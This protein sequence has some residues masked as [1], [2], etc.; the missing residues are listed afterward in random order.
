MHVAFI[1]DGNRRWAKK[2]NIN[3]RD[4]YKKGIELFS[5]VLQWS[6]ELGVNEVSIWAISYD[7]YFNRPKEEIDTLFSLFEEYYQT[8]KDK[9]EEIIKKYPEIENTR[10]YIGGYIE[11]LEE[12]YRKYAEEINNRIVKDEKYR[13]NFLVIYNGRIEIIKALEKMK[14][15]FSLEDS[16]MLNRYP[17]IIIRT[18]GRVR[19]SGFLPIQSEYSEWY[20]LEKLWP[21]FDKEDYIKILEDFQTRQRNFGK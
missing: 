1:P 11:V 4:A 7:N 20:F 2:N 14:N 17:D 18:G 16:L 6:K 3:L 10:I 21:E 19:T 5:K 12:K 13:V 8:Y 15:G 9:T